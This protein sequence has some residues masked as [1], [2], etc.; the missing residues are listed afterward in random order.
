MSFLRAQFFKK[1]G[2]VGVKDEYHLFNDVTGLELLGQGEEFL[3]QV[4]ICHLTV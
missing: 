2:V 1:K 3:A 4:F